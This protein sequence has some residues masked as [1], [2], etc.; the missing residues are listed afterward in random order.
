MRSLLDRTLY[1]LGRAAAVAAPAGLL[2]WLLANLSVGGQSLLACLSGALDPFGRLLG[3]D[4]VILL[5]FILGFP[6]NELVIP[7]IAM[8]YLSGT[9]LSDAGDTAVLA[10]LFTENGWNALTV[11][12]T[13]LFSVFHWPC[14]TTCLTIYR[15]TRSVKQTALAILLP[16]LIGMLLCLLTHGA[17]LCLGLG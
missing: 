17:A 16:T 1:V 9:T 5:A 15:E 7:L 14:S 6:A 11:I 2:I 13:M 10:S 3:M 12:N 8:M 4:G